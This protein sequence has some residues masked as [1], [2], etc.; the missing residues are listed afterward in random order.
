MLCAFPGRVGALC[1][2]AVVTFGATGTAEAVVI[3]SSVA[4]YEPRLVRP[5]GSA[6]GE[7]L[8]F[9]ANVNTPSDA[10]N[11]RIGGQNRFRIGSAYFFALPALAPGETIGSSGLRFTQIPDSAAAGQP[12]AFNA[13]L[14]VLGLFSDIS[15]AHDPQGTNPQINPSLDPSLSSLLYHDADDD[16]RDGL[17]TAVPRLEVQEDFLT[18]AEYLANGS[19]ANALRE[20]SAAA[21]TLLTGY[22][23]ALYAA[24]VPEG[25]FLVVTLNPDAPP[26][27][28]ITNRYQIASANVVDAG[29]RPALTIEVVPEPSTLGVLVVVGLGMLARRRR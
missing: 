27:D 14:R 10:M 12:P 18:P 6:S 2:V 24:G 29:Q 20:T 9:D 4:D 28:V 8:D 25:S 13:D 5:T 26:D 7:G 15:V 3:E 1:A 23:N 21:N 16:T 19:G 17:N 11:L 22:L